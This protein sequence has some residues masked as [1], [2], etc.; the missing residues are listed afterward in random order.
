MKSEWYDF[1][2]NE[3]RKKIESEFSKDLTVIANTPGPTGHLIIGINEKTGDLKNSPFSDSGLR[4]ISDLHKI[5]VKCVDRQ[6]DFEYSEIN[7]EE[8]SQPVII[9]IFI[10]PPSIDD[11]KNRLKKRRTESEKQISIRVNNAIKELKQ[12]NQYDYIVVNDS[13]NNSCKYF[14][15]ILRAE[16]CKRKRSSTKITKILEGGVSDNSFR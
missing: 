15:S 5:I 4:D 14:E 2:E 1:T 7:Y 3:N 10:I 16:L 12:Y 9:G 6:F 11:L 8:D 13:V